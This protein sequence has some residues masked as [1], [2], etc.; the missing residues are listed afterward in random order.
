MKRPPQDSCF[1]VESL[2]E[3]VESITT[4]IEFVQRII[5]IS[6]KGDVLTGDESHSKQNKARQL[7]ADIIIHQV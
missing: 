7:P 2:N 5:W 4:L 3:S 1:L 6:V